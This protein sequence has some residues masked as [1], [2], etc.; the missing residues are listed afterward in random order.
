MIER[1]WFAI[2]SAVLQRRKPILVVFLTVHGKLTKL[3]SIKNVRKQAVLN[4]GTAAIGFG[5]KIV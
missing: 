1:S 3:V 2:D 4:D 5:K